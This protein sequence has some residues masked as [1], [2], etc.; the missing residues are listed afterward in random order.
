MA[1]VD[2]LYIVVGVVLAGLALWVGITLFTAKDAP[3]ESPKPAPDSKGG[4]KAEDVK[5]DTKGGAKPDAK[6]RDFSDDSASSF[7]DETRLT[8]RTA[9]RDSNPPPSSRD[10]AVRS[11]RAVA[12]AGKSAPVVIL[13]PMR[14]R[15]DSHTEIRD[16]GTSAAKPVPPPEGTGAEEASPPSRGASP[17]SLVSAIGRS[18]PSQG[19][20]ERSEIVDR[21]RL[22]ILANGGG[23]RVQH[24][25]LS[26]VIVDGLTAAFEADS[27]ETFP[28]DTSLPPRADRLRRAALTADALV[29][30]RAVGESVD[31][32]RVGVLAAHFGPDNRRLFIAT[33]GTDRAYRLRG[34][35]V[36]QLNKPSL[37]AVKAGDTPAVEIVVAETAEGDV[38]VFGSD[39][40]FLA[41][42]DELKT[43]LKFDASIDRVAAHFVAAATSGG[44]RTG[45]TAIVV[46]VE[47]PRPSMRPPMPPAP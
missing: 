44:T 10:V 24:E 19:P 34:Q 1:D 32:S 8:R 42:G 20:T 2:V 23:Q 41:L 26:A 14:Q 22:F 4:A 6:L 9:S 40:A 28:A 30:S 12:I 33:A 15:L 17:F 3:D 35:E 36:L 46:R 47:P 5:S 29:K 27:S 13:P 16:D 45:M 11:E 21:H 18:D 31:V 38:Y 25:L 7:N 43:V 37:A 39:A